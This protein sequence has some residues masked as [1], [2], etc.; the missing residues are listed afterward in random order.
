MIVANLSTPANYFHA[1]R[2]QVKRDVKKPLILMTPKSLLRNPM[3]VSAPD[4]L[5]GGGFQELIQAEADPAS[6]ERLLFCSGKV[7]Y[8]LLKTM[9]EYEDLQGKIAIAR[10]EQFYPF[11]E[12]EIRNELERYK[13]V[14]NVLWV[15]EEP[16]NMGAW[17]FLRYRF[18]D[19]LEDLHGDC[20][21]R[22]GYA[23]R[24]ASASPATGSAKVHEL[25]QNKLIAEALGL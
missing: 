17:S 3:V 16:A 19:L 23:G 5:S 10:V 13:G 8:D 18:D 2:R 9:E 6:A 21:H 4:A 20:T 11:A 25:E 22:I 1:L 24:P 7:Y 15:Q 14:G 12:E